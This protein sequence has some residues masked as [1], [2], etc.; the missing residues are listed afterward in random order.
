MQGYTTSKQSDPAAA[1]VARVVGV[2]ED[3]RC[4]KVVLNDDAA[5]TRLA[6]SSSSR[7]WC[8]ELMH[9]GLG[10]GF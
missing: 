4:G 6:S 7:V 10:V 3:Q 9:K 2:V 8:S 1:V 5:P